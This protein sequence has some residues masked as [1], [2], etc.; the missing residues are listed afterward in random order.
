M[1]YRAKA[2]VGLG[3]YVVV[4]EAK[5]PPGELLSQAFDDWL[6]GGVTAVLATAAT[7]SV[8]GHLLNVIPPR[9]DWIHHLHHLSELLKS[10]PV[11]GRYTEIDWDT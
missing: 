9:Y 2:W 1:R 10:Y 8:A 4:V 6:T 7:L 5:A 3:V 11:D